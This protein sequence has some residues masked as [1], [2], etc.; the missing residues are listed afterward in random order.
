[1]SAQFVVF[2]IKNEEY[3]IDVSAVNGIL[4]AKKFTIKS[5]PGTPSVIEGMVNVRGRINYI[6]NLRAK[7]GMERKAMDNETKFIM[8]NVNDAATGCIVDEVTDIVKLEDDQLHPAPVFVQGISAKFIK[9][10]GQIEE[11]MI[12]ILDADQILSFEELSSIKNL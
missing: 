8:L 5:I 1:M 11:R 2:E 10:I 3:G 4:L 9:C 6:I 12:I 7:F